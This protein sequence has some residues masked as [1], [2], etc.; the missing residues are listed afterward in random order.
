MTD[1]C[2]VFLQGGQKEEGEERQGEGEWKREDSHHKGES[3]E[4]EADGVAHGHD[5]EIPAGDQ[6]SSRSQTD[7]IYSSKMLNSFSIEDWQREREGAHFSSCFLP[8]AG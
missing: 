7:C 3:A 8:G 4:E 5:H 6:V 1:Y 2:P